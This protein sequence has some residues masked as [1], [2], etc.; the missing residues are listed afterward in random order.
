LV[1]EAE[2]G[3]MDSD[4]K[5]RNRMDKKNGGEPATNNEDPTPGGLPQEDVED[6]PN[7][8]TVTPE[9]YPPE[10]RARG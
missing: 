5:V 4:R 7:V 2:F 9:D 3:N 8:G 10:D 6:R 1:Y